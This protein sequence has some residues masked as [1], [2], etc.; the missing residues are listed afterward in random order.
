MRAPRTAALALALFAVTACG[1]DGDV[2]DDEVG[3]EGTETEGE[4]AYEAELRDRNCPFSSPPGRSADCYT[5]FV[6]VDREDLQA[7]AVALPVAVLHPAGE[8]SRPP[9]LYL[10]GGPGGDA[11]DNAAA[12][13]DNPEAEDGDFIVFDQRGGGEA[14]P[15]LDCPEVEAAW[16]ET[17][18]TVASPEQELAVFDT[19]HAA[20]RDRLAAETKL[21]AFNSASNADDIE[22]LRVALGHE[23][24]NLFGVSYGTRVALEVMRRHPE[25]IRAV[26][27]DSV[28][29]PQA[30]GVGWMRGNAE[31]AIDRL[32]DGCLEEEFCA[33]SFPDLETNWE[34]ALANL[35][36]EPFTTSVTDTMGVPHELSITSS[37]LYAGLFNALYDAELIPLVPL[38]IFQA[39]QGNLGF[40]EDLA[41]QSLPLLTALAEGARLSID[42]VDG[43]A[44]LDAAELDEAY[45]ANPVHATLYAGFALPHCATWGVEGGPVEAT[46]AVVSDI[47][48]LILAGEFDPVTPVSQAE[49]AAETLGDAELYEFPGLGHAVTFA[50]GCAASMAQ[51]FTRDLSVDPTCWM[52]L[53]QD[54]F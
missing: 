8:P 40:L 37:D 9:T 43:G 24:W 30:A 14:L 45:A 36:A 25:G 21:S 1:D 50:S 19:A 27:L 26:V 4:P 48:T 28:Y 52:M 39:G 32:I 44:L 31:T 3:D 15:N 47:P 16:I 38:L 11:F 35:D 2:G 29:P 18:T 54:T 12:F 42:C 17:F 34:S 23:Q 46:E 10:H 5:L 33:A 22:D 20:C 13:F 7:G 41:A 49:Q 51:E 53:P 6:P